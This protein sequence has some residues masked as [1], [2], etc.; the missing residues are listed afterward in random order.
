MGTKGIEKFETDA[1]IVKTLNIESTPSYFV[2]DPFN[3]TVTPAG[4]GILSLQTLENNIK[5]Q[6]GNADE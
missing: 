2:I 6:F 1:G 3:N 5:A 4:D